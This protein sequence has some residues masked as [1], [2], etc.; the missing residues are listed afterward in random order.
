VVRVS[1]HT[2]HEHADGADGVDGVGGLRC[3]I[4]VEDNGIG[5]E[6]EYGER[7]FDLFQRLHGRDEYEGTGIGLAIC[8]KIVD[9]HNGQIVAQSSPGKGARFLV[10]LPLEQSA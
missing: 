8:R 6:P 7:I 1:A 2:I 4:V 5:F 3:E 9:R 10:T